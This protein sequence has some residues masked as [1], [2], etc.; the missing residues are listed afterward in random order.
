MVDG[1]KRMIEIDRMKTIDTWRQTRLIAWFM[2][3]DRLKD[4]TLSVHSFMP[5]PD[6]P[7]P[8]EL[9]KMNQESANEAGKWQLAQIEKWRKLRNPT[10]GT[11]N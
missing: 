8:E 9:I 1:R 11:S 10:Y 5:L 3:S 6:D 4:K 7:T 2:V